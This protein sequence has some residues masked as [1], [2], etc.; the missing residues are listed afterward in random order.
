MQSAQGTIEHHE[1][2]VNLHL[3]LESFKTSLEISEE[4]LKEKARKNT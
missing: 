2:I 3:S 4:V 1:N